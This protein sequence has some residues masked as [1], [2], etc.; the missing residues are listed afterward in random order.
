MFSQR[1]IIPLELGQ[2]ITKWPKLVYFIHTAVSYCDVSV[3]QCD[4]I[5]QFFALWASF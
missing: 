5:G 1:P 2:L 4:Q 3:N